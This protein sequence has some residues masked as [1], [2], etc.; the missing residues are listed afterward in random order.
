MAVFALLVGLIGAWSAP[1]QAQSPG[2]A[3]YARESRERDK[4]S[5]KELNRKL[6]KAAKKQRKARKKYAKAQRKAA[7]KANRRAK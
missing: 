5:S 3:E 1:V 4:K 7:E 2:V 6:K